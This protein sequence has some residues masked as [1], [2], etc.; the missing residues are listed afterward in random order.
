MNI[1]VMERPR[2][3]ARAASRLAIADCDIHPSPKSLPVEIYPYLSKRWQRHLET[4]GFIYRQGFPDRPGLPEGPAGR[5]AA[6]RL[7]ARRRPAGAATST[8]CANSTWTRT[9]FASAC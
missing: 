7:P 2:G 8:S 1:Q 3:A 5:G 4:Y 9:T 6:R